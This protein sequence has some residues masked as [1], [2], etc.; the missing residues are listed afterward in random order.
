[1][2]KR[3]LVQAHAGRKRFLVQSHANANVQTIPSASA[4]W[5]HAAND[6]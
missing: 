2:Y 5:P 1:M 3:I 6:S 4:R